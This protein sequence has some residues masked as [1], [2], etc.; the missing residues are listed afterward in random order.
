MGKLEKKIDE[1]GELIGNL[2]IMVKN[3]FDDIYARFDRIDER[4]EQIDERFDR[5]DKR[6]DRMENISLGGHDRR[7]EILEDKVG[8]INKKLGL[9]RG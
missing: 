5:M 4:F 8:V 9:K 2:A 7:I 1:L 3:G 6:F